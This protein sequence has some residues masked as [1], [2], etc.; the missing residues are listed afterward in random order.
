MR[1]KLDF[2]EAGVAVVLGVTFALWI[3][4]IATLATHR[5]PASSA[6]QLV[7][8]LLAVFLANIYYRHSDVN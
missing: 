2:G 6:G 7:I 8:F 3:A 5:N 4:S 1:L